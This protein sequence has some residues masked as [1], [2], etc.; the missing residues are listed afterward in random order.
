VVELL[1][2][3]ACEWPKRC[4]QTLHPFS[5]ILKIF[6]AIL[7]LIVAPPRDDFQICSIRWKGIYFRKRTLETASKSA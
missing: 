7:A 1:F 3:L 2:Q 6:S 4:A 5:Q